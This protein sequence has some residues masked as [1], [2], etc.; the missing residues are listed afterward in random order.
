MG[1]EAN[2]RR[3]QENIWRIEGEKKRMTRKEYNRL[4]NNFETE[5]LTAQR[6]LR[7]LATEKTMKK[8]GDLPNE[9]RDVVREF[10]A[11]HE[12]DFWSSRL[13]ESEKSKGESK[14]EDEGKREVE[15]E[16]RKREEEKEE[17]ETVTVEKRCEVWFLWKPMNFRSQEGGVEGRHLGQP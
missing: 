7:K 9:E 6:G 13:R 14:V 10:K 2:T 5:G 12:E 17:N 1:E 8:R 3:C 15:G 11:V 16:K 4:S